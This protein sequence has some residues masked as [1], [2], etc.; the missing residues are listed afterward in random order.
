MLILFVG[1]KRACQYASWALLFIYFL[2]DDALRIHDGLGAIIAKKLSFKVPFNLRLHEIGE[3]IV[4]GMFGVPLL[5]FLLYCHIRGSQAFKSFSYRL[6][7]LTF[8][9]LFFGIIVDM[10]HTAFRFQGE[11]NHIFLLIEDGGEMISLSLIVCY[12]AQVTQNRK[13]YRFGLV[14]L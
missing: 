14:K 8:I 7:G 11:L 10:I 5:A 2:L 4:T 12:I 9:F 6:S 13:H 3:I 1:T